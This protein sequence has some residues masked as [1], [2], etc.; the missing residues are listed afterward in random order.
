MQNAAVQRANHRKILV[1]IASLLVLLFVYTAVSK[2]LVFDV[3]KK[4]MVNQAI[5]S[6]LSA[7][8]IW[9]LPEIEL[10]TS[11]LLLTQ[12]FRMAGLWLSLV[13]MSLFTAYIAYI[14]TGLAG[15]QPCSCGG[16]LQVLGWK[17]HLVFNIFFLLLSVT[18]IYIA[19][20]ERRLLGKQ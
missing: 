9:T 8:L 14:L 10:L 7:A 18:G 4:Q 3:F 12:R 20:R 2:L 6:W 5:P 19:N 15:R 11:V 17:A 1:V 16:V 13:L